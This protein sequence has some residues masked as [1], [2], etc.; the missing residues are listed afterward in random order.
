MLAGLR[1][2]AALLKGCCSWDLVS[3]LSTKFTLSNMTSMALAVSRV[4]P[5]W[6]S[7]TTHVKVAESSTRLSCIWNVRLRRDDR[8]SRY[9]QTAGTPPHSSHSA[10]NWPEL[11]TWHRPPPQWGVF[12][13]GEPPPRTCCPAPSA[14]WWRRSCCSRCGRCSWCW[15]CPRP[16]PSRGWRER[17][18]SSLSVIWDVNHP[19]I[20]NSKLVQI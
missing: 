6:E 18:R 20:Y 9:L 10:L 2:L 11:G 1:G 16:R 17:A 3:L 14:R 8:D 19:N 13:R 15:R 4:C 12:C 7:V 5:D